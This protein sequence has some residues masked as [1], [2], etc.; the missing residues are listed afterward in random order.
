MLD[1]HE[2]RFPD[3]GGQI[4]G[5]LQIEEMVVG[6]LLALE[7]G[8]RVDAPG[9]GAAQGVERALLLGVLAVAQFRAFLE[10]D[11]QLVG[12]A[13]PFA[14][15]VLSHGGVVVR[16]IMEGLGGQGLA[17]IREDPVVLAQGFDDGLIVVGVA[18]RQDMPEIPGRGPKEG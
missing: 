18:E 5:H 9:A 13:V 10:A 1:D 14:S 16:G 3:F 6:Q 17:A 12:Q 2:G 4:P 11:G 15:Q 7:Q 8:G